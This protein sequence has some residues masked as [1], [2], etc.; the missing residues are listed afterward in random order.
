MV[1]LT[2]PLFPCFI[3]ALFPYKENT[4]MPSPLA[5]PCR[6]FFL[7]RFSL[8]LIYIPVRHH[9]A[10]LAI[11]DRYTTWNESHVLTIPQDFSQVY[12][13]R[14]QDSIPCPIL[15]WRLM[16]TGCTQRHVYLFTHL[17]LF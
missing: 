9:F 12:A 13:E 6:E 11:I 7:C 17:R 15:L 16:K 1:I 4:M 10:R 2:Y 3:G 5:S 8:I 14:R